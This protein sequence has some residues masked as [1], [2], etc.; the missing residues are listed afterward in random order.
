MGADVKGI[1]AGYDPAQALRLEN[2]L[3]FPLYAASK[4]V[5]R[6]YKPLLDPLSLTYTQ[7]LCMMVLWEYGPETVGELG[8][9]LLLD[10]GTLTQVLK[11]LEDKGY[12]RRQRSGADSR[13]VMVSLTEAGTALKA[14]AAEVP[15]RLA[16]TFTTLAPAEARELKRLLEKLLGRGGA[17]IGVA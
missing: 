3:C 4:E 12:V 1:P 9:R 15:F 13:Q 11:K 14:Q 2:Q 16:C 6:R 8:E 5:I 7:Y 10:S 17:F